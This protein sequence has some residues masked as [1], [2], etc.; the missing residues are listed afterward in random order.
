MVLK[1]NPQ[2]NWA[3]VGPWMK[4][5]KNLDLDGAIGENL[6]ILVLNRPLAQT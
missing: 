2:K 6:Q 5:I 3:Q 1:K 4:S